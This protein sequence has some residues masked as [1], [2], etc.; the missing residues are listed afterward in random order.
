MKESK[1]CLS[2]LD[3]FLQSNIVLPVETK[4]KGKDY[5]L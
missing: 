4:V 1:I 3:P 5:V 2:A